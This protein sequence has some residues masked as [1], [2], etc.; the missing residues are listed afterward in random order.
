MF[1]PDQPI[2]P[3]VSAHDPGGRRKPAW[4]VDS[5]VCAQFSDCGRYRYALTEV[6][7][8]KRPT[9]MFLLM[10]PSVAGVEHA[11]PTL[12]KTGRLARAWGYGGQLVG[13]MH[14][15]RVTDSKLL[16][17]V[18]DPVGPG[19]DAAL[20][21]MAGEARMVVLAYGLPPKTL[22]PRAQ[23]VIRMLGEMASLQFLR[24]TQDGTPA[25]P[26]Y[27]PRGLLPQNYSVAW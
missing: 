1:M 17:G 22:R 8:E 18:D 14:A 12:I 15:Y 5:R 13:N 2:P 20:L 10:N 19:N 24:L 27:L 25:H 16:A 26:L 3:S 4:P 23:A 7:D 21:E 6:W 9:V 11:D